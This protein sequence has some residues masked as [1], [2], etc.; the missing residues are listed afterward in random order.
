MA[1]AGNDNKSENYIGNDFSD[2]NLQK[3]TSL[4]DY[5]E[6]V[7]EKRQNDSIQGKSEF[8]H[9]RKNQLTYQDSNNLLAV[10]KKRFSTSLTSRI[11]QI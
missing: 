3:Q 7:N 9:S 4:P 10:S 8:D 6:V 2:S 11:C 1:S 5:C